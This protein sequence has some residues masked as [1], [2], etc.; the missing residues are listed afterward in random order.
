M[1]TVKKRR[2]VRSGAGELTDDQLCFLVSGYCLDGMPN[3][4]WL[5]DGELIPFKS[6]ADAEKAWKVHRAEVLA[7]VIKEG[8]QD[9][10]WAGD[11]WG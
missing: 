7:Q 4:R 11:R 5:I 6:M 8:Y 1:P 9:S 10:A 2:Y 3:E